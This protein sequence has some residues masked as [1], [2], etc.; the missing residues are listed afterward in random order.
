[1][2]TK[3][4]KILKDK[5]GAALEMA[6]IFM[7]VIFCF[8]TLLTTMTLT[9]RSRIKLEK[10][11]FDMD[12]RTDQLV[13]DYILEI[14][15]VILT[16]AKDNFDD[17]NKIYKIDN[18]GDINIYPEF[19][20]NYINKVTVKEDNNNKATYVTYVIK[21]TTSSPNIELEVV[22]KIKTIGYEDLL[23][24]EIDYYDIK[25]QKTITKLNKSA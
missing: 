3:L 11:F 14:E 7:L 22:F 25:I 17:D 19:I 24:G 4:K 18:I 16:K 8:C 20:K 21:D 1:M 5:K 10:V 2:K 6:I 12:L 15:R 9:S 23:T 13:E